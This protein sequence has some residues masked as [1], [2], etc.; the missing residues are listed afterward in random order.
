MYEDNGA[1][2]RLTRCDLFDNGEL[3]W[4]FGRPE[5]HD[6][7]A[8]HF[9]LL[10]QRRRDMPKCRCHDHCVERTA[11]RPSVITVSDLDTHVATAK[12][13]QHLRSSF[14]QWRM[15]STVQTFRTRR[16]SLPA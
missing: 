14:G 8:T 2:T 5:G 3:L 16:A 15:I 12:L 9:E 13:S 10:N 1:H 4:R 6:E 7:P 11:F